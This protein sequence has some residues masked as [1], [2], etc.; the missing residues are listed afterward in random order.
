MT[1]DQRAGERQSAIKSLI[2]IAV[3][4]LLAAPG[5]TGSS[6]NSI[7]RE[8]MRPGTTAW[9]APVDESISGYASQVSALPGARVQLHV[10]VTLAAR[11][12]VRVYRLGWYRGK[13]GRLVTVL[14]AQSGQPQSVG[15]PDSN[16]YLSES[17]PVTDTLRIGKTWVSGYY[18]LQ[19]RIVSGVNKGKANRIPLIVR[20][21]R[22]STVLVQAAV[23]TWQAYNNWGGRSLYKS[24]TGPA[25]VKVSF[26]RPYVDGAD[27]LDND[28][29]VGV[30]DAGQSMLNWEYPLA[31]FLEK[32]GYDVSYTTDVDITK[33]PAELLRH[34]LDMTAGHDEY[35][36]KQQRDGFEAARDRG[37]NL[38]LMG[39]NTG[40]WQIRYEDNYRT[41]VEYRSNTLDPE[42]NPALKTNRFRRLARPRPECTL[43]GNMTMNGVGLSH[44]F[45]VRNASD[46]WMAGTGFGPG[47]ILPGL[48]GY[49]WDQIMPCAVPT[50]TVFFHYEGPSGSY[51]DADALRYTAKS[52]A[53]VFS[54]GSLQFTWGL[55]GPRADPRLQRFM[56]NAIRAMTGR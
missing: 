12:Q 50:P 3:M 18:L 15:A 36:S 5:A 43:W 39:A 26:N 24:F 4:A 2:V 41:L 28:E 9:R 40:Y 19:L 17:W 34:K 16:G 56:R 48:V 42:S 54:S 30:I 49:E 23:T 13:G 44:D 6:L 33:N 46:P 20:S 8:N 25:G 22:S 45:T 53:V 37:V 47:D 38:A 55:S 1:C 7:R 11:Y 52:G 14:P 29:A 10:S 31:S 51:T 27:N 21:K 35:W 32:T